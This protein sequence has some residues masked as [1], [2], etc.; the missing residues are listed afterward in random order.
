MVSAFISSLARYSMV[1]AWMGSAVG[2]VSSRTRHYP[3]HMVI[4][5]RLKLSGNGFLSTLYGNISAE[6]VFSD[7]KNRD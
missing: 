4:R 3:S 5:D 2:R 1:V 6:S 7:K